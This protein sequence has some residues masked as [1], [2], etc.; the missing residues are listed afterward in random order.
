MTLA[1]GAMLFSLTGCGWFSS[2]APLARGLSLGQVKH[3][4]LARINTWHAISV[5]FA[6]TVSLVGRPTQKLGV[7]LIAET[8]PAQYEVKV[9]GGTE[10][11]QIISTPRETLWFERGRS[12]YAVMASAP[13]SPAYLRLMG[14]EL[15]A[16]VTSSHMTKVH[17]EAG[18]IARLT[19][20]SV[21]PTGLKATINLTFNFTTN[22]PVRLV[23]EWSGG[24]ITE[25]VN[26][27]VVNPTV[28]RSA[29]SFVPPSGVTPTV[30]QSTDANA[31][32]LPMA[33]LPFSVVLPPSGALDS[34][35]GVDV[36]P[37]S[38]GRPVLILS[39]VTPNGAPLVLTERKA[40]KKSPVI[41]AG[42]T[43]TVETVGTT[44]VT[45]STLPSG[46][47]LAMLSL[48][49]TQI[50]VQGRS[51]DVGAV[52]NL[53]NAEGLTMTKGTRTSTSAG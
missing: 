48:G 22:T 38:S 32:D 50:L 21:L 43:T 14:T 37:T 23:A 35:T 24:T 11:I 31:L 20:Q 33:T 34:L 9:S 12:H 41:P 53:W 3:Q 39:Y 45:I 44:A 2:P 52:I 1:M 13:T 27:F 40:S 19:M 8:N 18:N 17:L 36:G 49:S 4:L 28:S 6:D 26:H 47:E 42:S 15:P 5:Q 51:Q 46:Q 16:M 29:F 10:P 30:A 25:T 7:S